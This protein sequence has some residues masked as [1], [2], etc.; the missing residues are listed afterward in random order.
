MRKNM[1]RTGVMMFLKQSG[2][3]N[4]KHKCYKHSCML[5]KK[6][7]N[8]NQKCKSKCSVIALENFPTR[9]MSGKDWEGPR[10][11]ETMM[12]SS[13]RNLKINGKVR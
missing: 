7:G 4:P 8:P 3:K 12:S 1:A 6:S 13:T 10:E 11:I 5:L 9:N 2:N